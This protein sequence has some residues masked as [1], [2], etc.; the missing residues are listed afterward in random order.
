M[1]HCQPPGPEAGSRFPG[2]ILPGEGTPAQR[3]G[4]TH[5][6]YA[7]R[8]A[9]TFVSIKSSGTESHTS[10]HLLMVIEP[11][12][13][14]QALDWAP[15]RAGLTPLVAPA[16][17]SCCCVPKVA[18]RA[19]AHALPVEAGGTEDLSNP[20]HHHPGSP[21]HCWVLSRAPSWRG[22]SSWP[23]PPK[24]AKLGGKQRP[25]G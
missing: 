12:A 2:K 11:A 23:S 7:H 24:S 20:A 14:G 15:A 25:R 3:G 10:V 9:L 18:Q 13:A 19:H 22:N 5:H 17:A 1:S 4:L 8:Y 16:T 6:S 21:Q